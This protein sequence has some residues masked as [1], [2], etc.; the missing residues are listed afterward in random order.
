MTAAAMRRRRARR[1]RDGPG[2]R[3]RVVSHPRN[4]GY[5]AA[6]RTGFDAATRDA[7]F[8][9]DSDGQFDPDR[10][11]PAPGA[12]RTRPRGLRV[13][14]P[15]QG[16]V[17]CGAS[18]T[19]RSSA[20]CGSDSAHDARRQLRLQAVPARRRPGAPCRRSA[21]VHRAAGA[22]APE[23]IPAHGRRRAPLPADH[24][25]RDRSRH[26]R[27][28]CARSA[29]SGSCATTRRCSTGSIRP[30]ET[31]GAAS[32]LWGTALA[33]VAVSRLLWLG[34]FIA[35]LAID[36]PGTPLL[37][38]I[39]DHLVSWDAVSYLS[40]AAHGYPAH[41]DYRDAFLPGFPL[42]VRAVMFVDA[43]RRDRLVAGQRR[44][45]D[46]RALVPRPPGARRARSG[47]AATFSVWLLAL[48]PTALF[49]IAP[50]S[51]SDLHR[52]RRGEPVLR[53]RRPARGKAIVAAALACAFRL[54][55]LA[56]IPALAVE[57][58]RRTGWRPRPEML[59]RPARGAAARALRRLHAGPYR[60]CAG[61]PPR[62]PPA[63]VRPAA[64]PAVDGIRRHLAHA[65][66]RHPTER[67]GRSSPARSRTVC[68][69]WCSALGMW[70]SSRIPRSLAL[71]CT[72]AWL[73][74]ASLPFWRSQPRYSLALFPAVLLVSDLTQRFPRARPAMLGASAVLMCAGTWIFAQGRWLG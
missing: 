47:R 7:V 72:I 69:G 14:H 57:Q 2:T 35:V 73:M 23:R 30:R 45:R 19:R 33:A 18:I 32:S 40:I 74:T 48:A 43:R 26:P 61:A 63:V 29:S 8:L 64:H 21:R 31:G 49:L 22:R 66:Q 9:M 34:V 5:G 65:G 68:S 70:M 59:L 36:F 42:V 62:R 52:I 11:L 16:H 20:S 15:A 17:G 71:Y 56:L 13:S 1:A 55:G 58:L 50:F 60:R 44:R 28:R 53:A 51:E 6:L 38:G 25:S 37:T 27:G 67:R 39:H 41:L 54:T 10:D 46:D 24:R 3:V 12:V 4:R